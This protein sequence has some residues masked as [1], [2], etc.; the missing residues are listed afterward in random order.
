MSQA[1]ILDVSGSTPPEVATNYITDVNSPAVPSLNTLNVFGGTVT[2]DNPKGIQT[3]GSSGS[4]T[5]TVELTNR[6]QGTAT[7]VGASTTNVVTFPLGATPGTYFF[8]V[9]VAAFEPSTPAGAGYDTFT[10]IRTDGSAG[11]IIG[12][13]DSIVH[14]DAALVA[15]NAEFVVSTNSAIFQVTGVAGLTIDWVIVGTYIKVT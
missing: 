5:L 8:N 2:T 3:D 13:T 7:T 15:T 1:G 10:T 12:D 14:E 11:T 9:T 6:I 4:N